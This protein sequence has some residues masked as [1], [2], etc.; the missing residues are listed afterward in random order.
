MSREKFQAISPADFFYR[1]REIAGFDNPVRA[2]YTVIREL[3]ENSLDACELYQIPPDIRVRLTR[4]S[5]N[6]YQ[7]RVEDNGIGVPYEH[8]PSAFAQVLFGSKYTLRQSR[9]IFG[10]GG[11]M[12]ILYGQITTNSPVRVMSST[13]GFEK[14][15]FELMINIQENKPIIRKREILPNNGR[16]HGTIVEFKFEGDYNRAKPKIIEYFR[17]TSIVLPYAN[18]TFI[19]P[20]GILY[21]FERVTDQMPPPPRE[22]KPHP[23]GV[24]VETVK[25]MLNATK[26]STLLDFLVNNFHRVGRAIALKFLKRAK[27]NPRLNPRSLMQK[28]IVA[29]VKAMRHFKGFLPPD[30]SHLSP[31][32]ES[33][34]LKGIIR[35]FKPEFVKVVCRK[36]SSYG[37]HPFVV[38]AAIA[39]GGEIPP[40][41]SPGDVLVFRFANKIPLLY[42]L[43]N[44]VTMKVIRR[45]RWSRYKVD[46]GST[47]IAF[48]VHIC[49][50][51][52]PYKTVGKEY[53]AD[54]PEV[55]YEIEWALKTCARAL[56]RY[57]SR[58][59]KAVVAQKRFLVFEKYLPLIASF[60]ADLAGREEPPDVNK[61]LRRVAPQYA[62][63]GE[64]KP[65]SSS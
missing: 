48:F 51:K 53:I 2:T 37:G 45:I 32:G 55:E 33:L 13:G 61:L 1:N 5:E 36:P 16:W 41:S 57:L 17:Q 25:R 60:A 10:L 40:P 62:V 20:D 15:F 30:A 52:V 34:F 11:K 29:L 31:I 28:D 64:A 24:D 43:H 39:Y 59:E 50:T 27:L 4:V 22:V 49:S 56:R 44:D 46:L 47:P 65:R 14:Y 6:V 19:D 42:D 38:E 58:K 9:G 54:Q 3:V 63:V 8:I 21:R 26:S 7:I 18:I 23:Y 12:A 35:E